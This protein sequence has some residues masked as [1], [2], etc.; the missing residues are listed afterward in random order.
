MIVAA[1]GEYLYWKVRGGGTGPVDYAG[2]P[3]EVDSRP[4]MTPKSAQT[5]FRVKFGPPCTTY[6]STALGGER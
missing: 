5:G 6:D 1:I 4:L 2:G 3:G